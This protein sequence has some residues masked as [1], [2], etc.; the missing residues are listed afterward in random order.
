M[1]FSV[2]GECFLTN[3]WKDFFCFQEPVIKTERLFGK[4][5]KLKNRREFFPS[6][7][8][9]CFVPDFLLALRAQFF[10]HSLFTQFCCIMN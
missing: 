4:G 2:D 7:D 5:K 6:S 8:K 9:S 1:T 3:Y 10:I